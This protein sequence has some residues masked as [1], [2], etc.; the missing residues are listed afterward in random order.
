MIFHRFVAGEPG[1]RAVRITLNELPLA[2]ID[3]FLSGHAA[4]QHLP[5]ESFSIDGQ[6]VS[7]RPFILPHASRLT[8]AQVEIAGG[9]DGLRS[10][11]GFYV[12]RNRRLIIWGSWFRLIPKAELSKL[13]RVQVDI[14]N[15]LDHLWA[16]DI[17]KA[18]A[19]PPEEVRRKLDRTVERIAGRSVATYRFRGRR[20]T[21]AESAHAWDRIEERGGVRYDVSREHPALVALQARLADHPDCLR[22]LDAV[23]RILESTLPLDAIYADAAE[24]RFRR[25]EVPDE[26]E[27]RELARQI[28]AGLSGRTDALQRFV[29]ALPRT[30]PFSAHPELAQRIAEDLRNAFR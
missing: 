18:T 12:Y 7:V 29:D 26:G 14:P 6:N 5:P 1:T 8:L 24:H 21:T 15:G 25:A 4:T 27:L 13:A 17:R 22:Q 28:A 23:V 19:V 9:L 20:Q 3:P 16:I 30:D 11:Q 10:M 2:A